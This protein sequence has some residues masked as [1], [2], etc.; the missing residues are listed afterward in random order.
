MYFHRPYVIGKDYFPW[1]GLY[2][3]YALGHI[4]QTYILDYS[5]SPYIVWI[6]QIPFHNHV[7]TL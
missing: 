6:D 3:S 5:I 7:Y 2:N 1:I 4:S